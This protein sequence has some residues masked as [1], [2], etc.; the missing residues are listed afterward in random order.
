MLDMKKDQ[1]LL[2]KLLDM[3]DVASRTEVDLNTQ[4]VR[5]LENP[6]LLEVPDET[7]G[8]MATPPPPPVSSRAIVNVGE[9]KKRHHH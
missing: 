7:Y 8:T 5:V 6:K 2:A 9:K 3:G 4:S 1:D